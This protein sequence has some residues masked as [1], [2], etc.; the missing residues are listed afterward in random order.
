M[1]ANQASRSSRVGK[2]F[3][4]F[5][6]VVSFDV[7]EDPAD[8]DGDVGERTHHPQHLAT[9]NALLFVHPARVPGPWHRRKTAVAAMAM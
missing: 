5:R 9:V 7:A 2:T 6:I 3:L 1:R 8:P 4:F